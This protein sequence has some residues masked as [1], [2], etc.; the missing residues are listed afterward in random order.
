M[1][2]IKYL[3]NR[4]SGKIPIDINV[5]NNALEFFVKHSSKPIVLLIDEIDS[6]IG[7]TLLSV[8]RQIRA[9]FSNA[10]KGFPHSICLIGLRDVRDY[11][12]WSKQEGKNISTSSPF[13]IKSETLILTNFTQ[14]D[15]R[16][17]YQQHTAETGQKF[18]S[19]A[20]EYVYYL[21]K[22][23]PWLVN[24][25]AYQVCYRDVEDCNQMITKS[26]VERAKEALIKRRDTHIDSLLDK[27]CEERVLPIIEA[28]ITGE[29]HLGNI[30]ADDLQYVRDLGLVRHEITLDIP[31]H[32][33]LH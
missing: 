7:D 21:T 8:L 12:I 3:E 9:G 24:A 6:L 29:T 19:E 28:I 15:I 16:M 31:E 1:T 20:I 25:L 5:L 30:Q 33:K 22:G 11:R 2:V 14:D 32:F 4:I 26:D 10:P 23:Q 27:L 18:S 13:N 17:L